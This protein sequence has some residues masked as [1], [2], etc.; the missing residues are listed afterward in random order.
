MQCP[1]NNVA[2]EMGAAENAMSKGGVCRR[3]GAEGKWGL[4]KW[5][6]PKWGAAGGSER[7]AAEKG[8]AE[9]GLPRGG[10][11]AKNI[12]KGRACDAAGRLRRE[13]DAVEKMMGGEGAGSSFANFDHNNNHM[14]PSLGGATGGADDGGSS[15]VPSL[16]T[17]SSSLICNISILGE[18]VEQVQSMVNAVIFPEGGSQES[19][20]ILVASMATLLQEIVIIASSL[21]FT[22]QKMTL[23]VPGSTQNVEALQHNNI[24]GKACDNDN[25]I[26]VR[27]ERAAD[28]PFV[29]TIDGLILH[30]ARNEMGEED[31]QHGVRTDHQDDSYNFGTE[32]CD[33]IELDAADLLAKYTHYCQVCGKGFKRDANLR[34]HMRAHGDEYKSAAALS[35]PAKSSGTGGG[36]GSGSN[37][38]QYSKAFLGMIVNDYPRRKYSCPQEGCRWNKKHSKFQPLKS[39][40][41][42]KNHY[43]RSHCPKMY[44]CNRCNHKQFSLLSDL[45]TH[46]KHCGDLKWQCSCGTTFSRKDKLMGH[47][48]LFVGHSPAPNCFPD[49]MQSIN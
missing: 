5:G 4:P 2:A 25:M 38:G 7:G 6:L 44:I 22:C 11:Q 10:K 15:S 1:R 12:E 46:E 28:R 3:E 42:V 16:E 18:K 31:L 27:G 8:A 17:H 24:Q 37:S 49:E 23:N 21:L 43:K 19:G 47:V 26:S 35:N 33:I 41:C 20:A 13:D 39:M 32:N 9:R 14:L 45:R 34:M 30:E 36:G 29:S 40:I 48:A